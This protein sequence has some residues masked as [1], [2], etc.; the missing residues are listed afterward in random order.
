[1]EN[2][3]IK[4]KEIILQYFTK[5]DLDLQNFDVN[6]YIFTILE[7]KVYYCPLCF[8]ALCKQFK[9]KKFH[10]NI[11]SPICRNCRFCKENKCLKLHPIKTFK[12]D[13]HDL[14]KPL[15]KEIDKYEH[16]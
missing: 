6:H 1:M 16:R 9:A 5:C 10:H 7:D 14:I 2:L 3:K 12:I 13:L 4:T 15:I 8:G 11:D